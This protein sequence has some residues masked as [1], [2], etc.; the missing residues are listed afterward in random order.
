MLKLPLI[1]I[2][3]FLFI[4][5]GLSQ[6]ATDDRYQAY[7]E[8]Y[9]LSLE[10][11]DATKSAKE[12]HE[13]AWVLAQL[14][15]AGKG[16]PKDAKKSLKWYKRSAKYGGVKAMEY[17]I[18]HYFSV[19]RDL[20]KGVYWAHKAAMKGSDLGISSVGLFFE[21]ADE[22]EKAA[23]WYQK[24]AANEGLFSMYYLGMMYKKGVWYHKDEKKALFWLQKAA[25]KGNKKAQKLLQP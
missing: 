7:R 15:E 1:K 9:L 24:G 23:K 16:V 13:A 17:L 22:L 21:Q 8:V 6:A 11:F 25:E 10:A 5:V 3:F 12:K 19:K 14:Y 18:R 2:A 4:I 20:E